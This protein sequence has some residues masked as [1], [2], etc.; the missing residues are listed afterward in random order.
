MKKK[1]LPEKLYDLIPSQ[2]TMYMMVKYSLHKNLVQI[3]TSFSVDREIDFDVLKQAFNL[4]IA[5]NDSLRLRF[6]KQDK[7]IKQYFLPEYR[8]DDIPVLHFANKEEQ[9]A[10]FK[11]DVRRPVQFLKETFRIFFYQTD[12]VGNGLYFNVTHLAMDAMGIVIMYFDMLSIYKTLR[13]GAEMPAPLEPYE[14]YIQAEFMRLSDQRKMAR[15][16]D[17]YKKYFL[18]G[19]EPMYAGVHGPAFLEKTRKK[20]KN[21]TLRVPNAY[22]PLYDK[23][24]LLVQDIAAD[25]AKA[26]FDYCIANKLA[27]ESLLQF[28]LRT[29]CSAANSRTPDVFMMSMCSKRATN[30]EK[31]MGGCIAQPLQL[32]TILPE[33]MTFREAMAEMT[34]V[35]T[36]LF[37]HSQFPYP[38]ALQ[39]SRDLYNFSATQGPACM[40]FSWIPLPLGEM[41]P[42]KLDFQAYNLE[43]YFSP[44]YVISHPDPRTNGIRINYMYRV[45]LST[46]ADIRALHENAVKVILAGIKNPDC[47]VGALLDQVRVA[48]H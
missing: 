45:K 26:I 25:D 10:F 5:R 4:E 36:Q 27:P 21:P 14:K 18:K 24:E 35:R 23:C 38:F 13:T 33:T 19:G 47:T 40:M 41:L 39:I 32:R 44:L 29:Y 20:K 31:H 7:K 9:D 46:E 42:F 43:H 6:V 16:A 17:F 30:S 2:A 12:G 28:G 34:Y 22:N 8:M 1:D 48:Q 11:K 3:P 37:R 15:H